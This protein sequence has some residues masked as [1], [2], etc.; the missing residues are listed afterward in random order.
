MK[1]NELLKHY[2]QYRGLTQKDVAD[3]LGMT[4]SGYSKYE[5]GERKITVD[6]WMKLMM[7]LNIPSSALG[8]DES[9]LEQDLWLT[10]DLRLKELAEDIIEN[11]DN[12]SSD[13]LVSA[14]ALFLNE[15]NN[16][17]SEKKYILDNLKL[18]DLNK[19]IKG[20]KLEFLFKEV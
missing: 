6:I 20:L 3:S 8:N 18:D 15:F 16:I 10:Y 14:K 1:E 9:Y 13:E 2:R 4:H 5:R 19:T 12:M 7:I 17:Q 11:K